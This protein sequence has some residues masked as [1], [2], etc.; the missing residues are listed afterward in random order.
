MPPP[1]DV[2]QLSAFL[3]LVNFYG[4]FVKDLHNLR[5]SLDAL[6][7]KDAWT[8]ACQ[9]SFDRIKAI[10]KSDLL[11][12]HYDPS[13]PIVVAADASNSGIGAVLSH[14]FPDGS[15]KVIYHASRTLTPARK[16]YSQIE[17]EA[18]ALIFAVQKFH[19]FIHGRHFILKTDHKP[20][21]SIFGNK[22]GV[23]VYSANRLQ[24]WAT[25]LLN[26]NFSI[27]YVNTKDFGQADALSRLIS[28]HTSEPEDRVIAA[29]DT[30][31]TAEI[32]DN[33]NHLPVSFEAIQT[34]TSDDPILTQVINYTRSGCWPKIDRNSPLFHYY[35]R[36]ESLSTINGCLLTSSRIVIPKLLTR[37]VLYSYTKP[38]VDRP[39]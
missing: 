21:I 34:A 27:Q 39:E 7:K 8:P 11:L 17:K 5:V 6:T 1:K 2:S 19:R 12:T 36:R 10:L 35:N 30:E 23:P 15:E 24:R 32:L 33:C 9:S 37:R 28:P 14:Q 4:N 31:I 16:K 29:I 20:L 18:F 25:M 26:Y 38:I 13:L 3:G 22:K